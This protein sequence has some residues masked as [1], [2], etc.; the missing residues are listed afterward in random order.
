MIHIHLIDPICPTRTTALCDQF[1]AIALLA[2]KTQPSPAVT[3][4]TR[5]RLATTPH[6]YAPAKGGCGLADPPKPPPEARY[7]IH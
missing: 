2:I 3:I 1:V 4:S 6:A 7:G 5:S